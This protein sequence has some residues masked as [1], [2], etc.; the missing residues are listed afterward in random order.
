MRKAYH[1]DNQ[2]PALPE[3]KPVEEIVPEGVPSPRKPNFKH[4]EVFVNKKVK[5]E[6]KDEIEENTDTS[7]WSESITNDEDEEKKVEMVINEKKGRGKRGKDKKKRAKRP[8]TEKQLAHLARIRELSRQKREAKKLEKERLKKE[9]VKKASANVDKNRKVS[10]PKTSIKPPTPPMAIPPPQP[11]PQPSYE[12]FFHLMDRYEE[13][14]EKRNRVKNVKPK[15][16]TL[17]TG[18]TIKKE[19]R[20]KPPIQNVLKNEPINPFDVCFSYGR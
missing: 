4:N 15:T 12:Q 10:R 9:H 14:K 11:P 3:I 7:D 20:P 13:Y 1:E 19:H 18:R 16:Q 17:P 8:P 5:L 6:S 2:I